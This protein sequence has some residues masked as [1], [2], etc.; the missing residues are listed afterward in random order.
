MLLSFL[1]NNYLGTTEE[2]ENED[3]KEWRKGEKEEEEDN[4]S[5]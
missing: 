3:D 4:G 1:T 2:G 5:G